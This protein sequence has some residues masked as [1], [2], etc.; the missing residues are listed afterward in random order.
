M[1]DEPNEPLPTP[2]PTTTPPPILSEDTVLI[3]AKPG[4][5]EPEDSK[6]K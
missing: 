2:E 4:D 6:D 1:T 3:E 5:S